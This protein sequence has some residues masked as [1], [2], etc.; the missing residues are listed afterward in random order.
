MPAVVL[1]K[2]AFVNKQQVAA[3]AFGMML[4]EGDRWTVIDLSN[5]NELIAGMTDSFKD[6][7]IEK[8]LLRILP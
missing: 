4:K 3:G 5:D 2:I 1:T 8:G 6:T 7:L